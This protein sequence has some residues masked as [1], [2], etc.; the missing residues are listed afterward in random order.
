MHPTG[1]V[2]MMCAAIDEVVVL[3]CVPAKQML[4]IPEVM[5][6]R[7]CERLTTSKPL[8]RKKLRGT[9]SLGTAGVYIT[10]VSAGSRKSAGTASILSRKLI[11]APSRMRVLVRSEGVRSYP[12]TFMPRLRHQR[13]SAA[14]PMPPAPTKYAL[15]FILFIISVT[16]VRGG[17]PVC[18]CVF[19]LFG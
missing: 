3:P 11:A 14:M 15:G 7:A 16:V 12:A 10:S 8:S 6:P 18:Y 1:S 17:A 9:L 2:C 4:F 19:G 13:T 5:W